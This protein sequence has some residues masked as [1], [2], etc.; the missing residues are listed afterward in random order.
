MFVLDS[1]CFGFLFLL[2]LDG[3][4]KKWN[5]EARK[6][7]EE[8]KLKK[9]EGPPH[10]FNYSLRSLANLLVVLIIPCFLYFIPNCV[11]NCW[12]FYHSGYRTMSWAVNYK[13]AY[14]LL[15]HIGCRMLMLQSQGR[16]CS[17]FSCGA[18]LTPWLSCWVKTLHDVRLHRNYIIMFVAGS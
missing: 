2:P 8:V 16:S 14:S 12:L 4:V 5:G 18:A 15:F 9:W 6:G 1:Y 17:I 11:F 13:L 10:K 3:G 7:S